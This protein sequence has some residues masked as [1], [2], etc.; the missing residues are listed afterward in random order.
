MIYYK[1][2]KKTNG[3]LSLKKDIINIIIKHHI[4]L[5]LIIIDWISFFTSKF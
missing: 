3:A 1:L 5:N 4:F 2:A